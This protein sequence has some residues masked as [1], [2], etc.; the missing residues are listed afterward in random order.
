M[1]STILMSH[2]PPRH[3]AHR[4]GRLLATSYYFLLLPTTSYYFLLKYNHDLLPT[5]TSYYLLPTSSP[6][7]HTMPTRRD[8][9]REGLLAEHL[10]HLVR[11]R[12]RV[13]N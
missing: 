3:D 8:Q 6:R 4:E 10:K 12:V 1:R 5:T 7:Q 13:L 11:V 9:H 2:V